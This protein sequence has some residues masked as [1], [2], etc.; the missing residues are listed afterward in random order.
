V[1][2]LKGPAP[3]NLKLKNLK[4]LTPSADS[5]RLILIAH[6]SGTLAADFADGRRFT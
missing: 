3:E 4:L 6:H 5:P 1:F 2:S